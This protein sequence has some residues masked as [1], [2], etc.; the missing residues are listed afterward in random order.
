MGAVLGGEHS[1]RRLKIVI[2]IV[3]EIARQLL[4]LLL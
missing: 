3:L 1:A 4:H 2:E